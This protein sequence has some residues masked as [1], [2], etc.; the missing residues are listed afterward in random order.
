MDPRVDKPEP[1]QIIYIAD[2]PSQSEDEPLIPVKAPRRGLR[3]SR[4]TVSVAGSSDVDKQEAGHDRPTPK[5]K[6]RRQLPE[7]GASVGRR[8]G[9][10]NPV[11]LLPA[12]DSGRDS[13]VEIIAP[14][15]N[16]NPLA[17][18][19]TTSNNAGGDFTNMRRPPVRQTHANHGTHDWLID[20]SSD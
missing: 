1:A 14:P 17:R 18:H 5:P 10:N 9:P 3:S 12:R 11:S 4:N 20:D 6:P 13:S 8:L 7:R 16:S 15:R 2:T 19:E